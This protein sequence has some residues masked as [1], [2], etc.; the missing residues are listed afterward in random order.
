MSDRWPRSCKGTGSPDQENT[1]THG[2]CYMPSCAGIVL[3]LS[4]RLDGQPEQASVRYSYENGSGVLSWP[5]ALKI[6][7][8]SIA[9]CKDVLTCWQGG[10]LL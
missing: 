4:Q 9:Q 6:G 5:P 7:L 8:G 1:A 3:C 2:L 10:V